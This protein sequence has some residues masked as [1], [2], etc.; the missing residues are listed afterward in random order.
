M[1]PCQHPR[2]SYNN[3][4]STAP[5]QKSSPPQRGLVKGDG[6]GYSY[7]CRMPNSS[8]HYV[9]EHTPHRRRKVVQERVRGRGVRTSRMPNSTRN[10][11]DHASQRRRIIV[12][13]GGALAAGQLPLYVLLKLAKTKWYPYCTSH[14]LQP[15]VQY[16]LKVGTGLEACVAP[17]PLPPFLLA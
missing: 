14:S 15:N 9:F 8:S 2:A 3:S 13:I 5:R 6:G 4:T 17:P 10:T 12:S 1:Y 11:V 7:T 16:K